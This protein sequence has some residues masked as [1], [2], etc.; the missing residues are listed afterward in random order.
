[1]LLVIE[2]YIFLLLIMI[3]V[4]APRLLTRLIGGIERAGVHFA[5]HRGRAVLSVLF[6]SLGIRFAVLPIEPVPVPGFHDEFGYL[7]SGDTLAHGRLANPPHPLWI[8]FESMTVIQQPTYSSAFYPAQ[9]FFLAI[10]QVFLG[11]PFWGVW[12]STGL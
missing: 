6:L 12:L 3:C 9:G 1:M 8:H 2:G 7:L 4:G 11:R 5:A 10:G